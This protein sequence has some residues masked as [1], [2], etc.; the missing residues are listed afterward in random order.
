M[1]RHD[2]QLAGVPRHQGQ[3]LANLNAGNVGRDRVKCAA[4]FGRSVGLHIESIDM[5][6]PAREE[7]KQHI[8]RPRHDS[9]TWAS[10]ARRAFGRASL[11]PQERRKPT[12]NMLE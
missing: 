12:D 7:D 5:A 1:V 11:R 6:R 3:V 9:V 4:D 2:R 10:S 8:L